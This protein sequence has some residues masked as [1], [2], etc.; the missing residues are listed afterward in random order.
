MKNKIISGIMAFAI[1]CTLIIPHIC[2]ADN[3][4]STS[5]ITWDGLE[6]RIRGGNLTLQALDENISSIE[7]IDYD[8]L[9]NSMKLQLNEISTAQS[10]LAE[11]GDF[12]SL[13]TLNQSIASLRTTYEDIRDGKLQRDSDAAVNQLRNAQDQ[14]VIAGQGLY[15]GILSMEQ[16]LS[17]GERGLQTIERSLSELRLRHTLGQVS[18]KTVSELERTY[19]DTKSQLDTLRNTIA[20][21]KSQLQLLMGEEPSGE[22]MLAPLPSVTGEE[23]A[24]IDCEADLTEAKKKSYD[25]RSAEI[26]LEKAQEE[27][28]EKNA[29]YISG[30]I[31]RYQVMQA[32]HSRDAA[33][34]TRRSTELD[35]ELSFRNAHRSL[36]NSLQSWKNKAS[37]VSHQKKLLQIAEKQF[38]LG[39]ISR[40][41]LL[42]ARDNLAGA[43]SAEE[44]ARRD[45]FTALNNYNNALE[46]GILN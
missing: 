15:I 10:F 8:S 44:T 4:E 18:A 42:T 11:F 36:Q 17:D 28:D 46:F 34:L 30:G 32:A 41:A 43:Q 45:Y 25:I 35:F 24:D 22:L 20:T 37:A 3:A 31:K 16:S 13:N 27:L 19:D 38:S 1:A 12:T 7:L 5:Q 23:L 6:D 39:R 14:V 9:Y 33:D 21:Y 40:F 26:A 29:D 2:Y